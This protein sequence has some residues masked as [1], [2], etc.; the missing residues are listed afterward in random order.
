MRADGTRFA[1][2]RARSAWLDYLRD[3]IA[4]LTVAIVP[5]SGHFCMLEQPTLVTRALASFVT[6]LGSTGL[7]PAG[8]HTS[9]N[10]PST[11]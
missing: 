10:P 3:R 4:D 6:S 5:G 11:P 7:A 9:E 1:L 2:A 8:Y